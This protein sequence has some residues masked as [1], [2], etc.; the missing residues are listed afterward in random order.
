[1]MERGRRTI[2][3][4]VCLWRASHHNGRL[5]LD[6]ISCRVARLLSCGIGCQMV[7]Y[8]TGSLCDP[9]YNWNKSQ[10][11]PETVFPRLKPLLV[12][13]NRLSAAASPARELA[14]FIF[15]KC[16]ARKQNPPATSLSRKPQ[17]SEKSYFHVFHLVYLLGTRCWNTQLRKSGPSRCSRHH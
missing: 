12:S 4:C 2:A 10:I 15:F 9:C 16:P 3:G 7:C 1:M 14:S 17:T 5:T 8:H 11:A 6:D 13:H